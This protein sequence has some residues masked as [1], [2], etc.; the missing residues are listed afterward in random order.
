MGDKLGS[1][2][3]L[4]Q[5]TLLVAFHHAPITA[6]LVTV[7]NVSLKCENI[8][9]VRFPT[10]FCSFI[11]SHLHG[12]L[13]NVGLGYGLYNRSVCQSV[14]RTLGVSRAV[15]AV[16]SLRAEFQTG[17]KSWCHLGRA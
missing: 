15:S 7:R 13:I 9:A 4:R 1:D 12:L 6:S 5:Q 11:P 14:K 3:T 16:G 2:S 17:A 8:Y 10:I